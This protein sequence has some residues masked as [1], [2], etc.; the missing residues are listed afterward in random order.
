MIEAGLGEPEAVNQL[1]RMHNAHALYEGDLVIYET[2]E[3]MRPFEK[4]WAPMSII[5][6]CTEQRVDDGGWTSSRIR[7]AMQDTEWEGE[8]V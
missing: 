3:Q 6:N 2:R 7:K 1:N 4:I 8:E 5:F